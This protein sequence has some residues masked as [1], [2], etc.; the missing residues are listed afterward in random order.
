MLPA[1]SLRS[2]FS[3]ASECFSRCKAQVTVASMQHEEIKIDK[4]SGNE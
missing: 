4:G 1:A 2:S 3:A